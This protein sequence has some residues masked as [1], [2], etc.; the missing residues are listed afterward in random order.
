MDLELK[1]RSVLITGSSKG[2]GLACA[3][4]FAREG[5]KVIIAGRDSARLVTAAGKLKAAGSEVAT[6]AGDLGLSADRDRLFAAHP[7]VDVLVN[8]AGA[9]PGGNLFDVTLDRW[10]DAWQLKVFGYIHLTKLYLEAMKRRGSGVII[11]II[12]MAGQEP[13]WD[14]VCGGVGNAGL[15]AF[16]KAVGAQS[17]DWNVRVVGINPA[18][19][20]TDRIENL[21]R[22][23]SLD[24]VG[25]EERWRDG[26]AELPFGRLAEASEIAD[27][28]LVMASPRASYLSGT[29]IDV[30]A[31]QSN[32]G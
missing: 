32:K 7:A 28:A 27:L 2:I 8:N 18:G 13:R 25:D 10:I 5:A 9:I 24:S 29:V 22:K 23:K 1:G 15:I 26:L 21:L 30:D 3:E 16:T 19:T 31:G 20:R 6:F 12:G 17:V 11:N 4:G 14:Y